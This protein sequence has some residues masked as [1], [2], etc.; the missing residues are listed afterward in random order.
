MQGDTGMEKV[1]IVSK[2]F[3]LQI[4]NFTYIKDANPYLIIERY[5]GAKKGTGRKAGWKRDRTLMQSDG[6]YHNGWDGSFHDITESNGFRPNEIAIYNSKQIFD[7]NPASYIMLPIG[8]KKMPRVVSGNKNKIKFKQ[9]EEKIR[10]HVYLRLRVGY[11]I[12]GIEKISKPL[13]NFS[14]FAKSEINKYGFSGKVFS[15]SYSKL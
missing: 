4:K 7:I 2:F 6:V 9:W 8:N 12:G 11:K 5:T 14:I 3:T 15:I 13:I 1:Q 10:Q